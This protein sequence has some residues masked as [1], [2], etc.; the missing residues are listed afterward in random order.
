MLSLDYAKVAEGYGVKAYSVKT[1]EELKDALENDK[2]QTIFTL[3]DI[4]VLSK[5]MTHDYGA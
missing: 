4:K 3:I 1:P 2:K 5:T